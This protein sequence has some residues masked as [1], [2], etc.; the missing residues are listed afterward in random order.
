[1]SLK[2]DGAEDPL[3]Q[4]CVHLHKRGE[5]EPCSTC[6]AYPDMPF[7]L[8][9]GFGDM[10]SVRCDF[11]VH[12]DKDTKEEPCSSCLDHESMPNFTPVPEDEDADDVWPEGGRKDDGGKP[13]MDLIAPEMMVALGSVLEYGARK[14]SAR[15]WEQGM[16]WGRVFAAMMRHMWAWWR[17]EA[18]DPETG[19]S[20]LWHAACCV[21]FLVAY[22]A[23]EIGTDDR[24]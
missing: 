9:D 1:M 8:P 19:M 3:C 14:Y 12:V 24:A 11:C 4:T 18:S 13:R 2:F 15:N 10:R 5:E 17:G 16:D 22:E 21:M 6:W 23:R 7:Y 20:H